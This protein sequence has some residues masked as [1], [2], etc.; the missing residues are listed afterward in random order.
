[1]GVGLGSLFGIAGGAAAIQAKA[2]NA[3]TTSKIG[4]A[5]LAPARAA[6]RGFDVIADAFGK[7]FTIQAENARLG[8]LGY[9]PDNI[10]Q[11][12]NEAQKEGMNA[13]AEIATILKNSIPAEDY[14]VRKQEGNAEGIELP[15]QEEI[16]AVGQEIDPSDPRFGDLQM[17]LAEATSKIQARQMELQDELGTHRA[18]G[19]TEQEAQVSKELATI[20]EMEGLASRIANYEAEINTDLQSPDA[21]TRAKAKKRA[22]DLRKLVADF[23]NFSRSGEDVDA[24]AVIEGDAAL[25]ATSANVQPEAPTPTPTATQAVDAPPADAQAPI[26]PN[27]PRFD[28]LAGQTPAATPDNYPR[29]FL[30]SLDELMRDYNPGD[31]NSPK[32]YKDLDIP[33]EDTYVAIVAERVSEREAYKNSC[34]FASC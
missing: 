4:S 20:I 33:D 12:I 6:G 17:R 13:K 21:N 2:G 15:S 9:T 30:V 24:Q 23:D 32:N 14:M 18:A 19:D 16:D 22:I 1:M 11:L 7:Q 34:R 5:V 27:D 29:A 3:S 8:E 10:A 31:P 25:Q 28:V 26:D